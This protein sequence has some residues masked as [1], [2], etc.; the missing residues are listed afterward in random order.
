MQYHMMNGNLKVTEKV[1]E[2]RERTAESY[3]PSNYGQEYPTTASLLSNN[4]I[5]DTCYYCGQ[6][7]VSSHCGNMTDVS[8]RKHILMRNGR[9]LVCL[10][11]NNRAQECHSSLT[12][13][14]RH[15][16]TICG[17]SFKGAS[18]PSVSKQQQLA[19]SP[20]T[21]EPQTQKATPTSRSVLS[22]SW[23]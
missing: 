18:N 21:P 12:C 9:C 4:P 2:A 19:P 8:R 3:V 1:V 17:T 13:G 11:R 23:M 14:K 5:Q 20:S 22:M 10:K 15:H 7:H 16:V 6:G